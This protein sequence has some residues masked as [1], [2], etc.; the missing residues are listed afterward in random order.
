[1]ANG[2]WALLAT[3]SALCRVW[4][5]AKRAAWRGFG[6]VEDNATS[7]N[8]SLGE[9]VFGFFWHYGKRMDIRQ[10]CVTS[11]MAPPPPNWPKGGIKREDM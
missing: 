11:G 8:I 7:A 1:M 3:R 2:I 10:A 6:C 5:R 9:L 4:P